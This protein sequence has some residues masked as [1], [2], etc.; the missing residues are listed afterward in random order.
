MPPREYRSGLG[1]VE[2]APARGLLE[3]WLSL[4]AHV[5]ALPVPIQPGPLSGVHLLGAG[6]ADPVQRAPHPVGELGDGDAA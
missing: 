2:Q 3:R 4:D 1:E 6:R 5:R